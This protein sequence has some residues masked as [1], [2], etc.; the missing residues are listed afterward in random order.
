MLSELE[1]AEPARAVAIMRQRA[2]DAEIQ[3]AGCQRLCDLAEAGARNAAGEVMVS[4]G[5]FEA[6]LAGMGEHVRS[7][8]VQSAGCR[9]LVG[10]AG[11]SDKLRVAS[12]VV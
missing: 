8:D 1:T 3:A 11:N 6:V 9:A 10:L 5:G 7:A 2:A 4:A 12:A